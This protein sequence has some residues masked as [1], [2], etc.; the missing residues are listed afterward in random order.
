MQRYFFWQIAGSFFIGFIILGSLSAAAGALTGTR[1]RVEIIEEGQTVPQFIDQVRFQQ[2]TFASALFER[3][4][5]P[6]APFT[7]K[8]GDGRLLIWDALQKGA[9]GNEVTWHG[10]FKS[11]S[12]TGKLIWTQ[13]GKAGNYTLA[14]TPVVEEEIQEEGADP[15]Q[16]TNPQAGTKKAGSEKSR[17]GCSLTR[18]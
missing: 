4:G 14:G 11:D 18:E 5:Y 12:M 7:E 17:W 3:R 8:K 6:A 1:W 16:K 13:E 2:G 15:D 9:S 10:E